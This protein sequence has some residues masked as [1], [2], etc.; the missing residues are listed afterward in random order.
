MSVLFHLLQ[1]STIPPQSSLKQ[2]TQRLS[3]IFYMQADLSDW[4]GKST[5]RETKREKNGS[6]NKHLVW[7]TSATEQELYKTTFWFLP[8]SLVRC[9]DLKLSFIKSFTC[10]HFFSFCYFIFVTAHLPNAKC[11]SPPD[12]MSSLNLIK[13][14]SPRK[15]ICESNTYFMP[16]SLWNMNI[17]WEI[18]QV[19]ALLS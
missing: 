17:T 5:H 4:M 3:I 6:I 7:C 18:N 9:A 14:Y 19:S 13:K 2:F 15:P 12:S 10:Q 16:K 8:N 11:S 1:L